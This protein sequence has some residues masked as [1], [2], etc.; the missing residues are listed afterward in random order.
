MGEEEDSW[1]K[2]VIEYRVGLNLFNRGPPE[3]GVQFLLNRGF[4]SLSKGQG[5]LATAVAHLLASRRGLS[6]RRVA[7]YL[8]RGERRFNRLVLQRLMQQ[9]DMRRLHVDHALRQVLRSLRLA[10]EHDVRL[11]ADAFA[12]AYCACNGRWRDCSESAD[13][14]WTD[15]P[16]DEDGHEDG[17]G[18]EDGPGAGARAEKR[19]QAWQSLRFWR[20]SHALP[21]LTPAQAATLA[22]ALVRLDL[23]WRH[24]CSGPSLQAFCQDLSER[25]GDE[26]QPDSEYV[27]RMYR[28]VTERAL[29]PRDDHTDILAD[30]QRAPRLRRPVSP[31]ADAGHGGQAVRAAAPDPLLSS[32]CV[33]GRA[34]LR[35]RVVPLQRPAAR[36]GASQGR[37]RLPTHLHGSPDGT[38][39]REREQRPS[40][41]GESRGGAGRPHLLAHEPAQPA[42]LAAR[43]AAL[44]GRAARAQGHDESATGDGRVVVAESYVSD[45]GSSGCRGCLDMRQ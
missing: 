3:V 29:L 19:R 43:V 12:L 17:P 11:L 9:H 44:D 45:A 37:R 25:L 41:R 10:P 14:G 24:G 8:L 13:S 1:K 27:A 28:R 31:A 15:G 39:G 6:L 40:V 30:V 16:E 26:W 5:D 36:D 32:A 42:G 34:L 20:R 18:R 35:P 2:R 22:A 33:R 7:D 38:G 4:V 23:S 21:T